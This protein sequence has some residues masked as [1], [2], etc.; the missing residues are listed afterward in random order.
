MLSRIY[1]R[2]IFDQPLFGNLVRIRQIVIKKYRLWT[3]SPKGVY[4][5][6]IQCKLS[7]QKKIGKIR[8]FGI[9]IKCANAIHLWL[10]WKIVWWGLQR[11]FWGRKMTQIK[12]RG[13]KH[14]LVGIPDTHKI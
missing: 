12:L 9:L 13:N 4:I 8:N 14:G 2:N 5:A 10:R 7:S 6:L 11:T 3:L 1:H